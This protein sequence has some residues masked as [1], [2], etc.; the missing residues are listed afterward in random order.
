MN[1][2]VVSLHWQR[3]VKVP[4]EIQAIKNFMLKHEELPPEWKSSVSTTSQQSPS[5]TLSNKNLPYFTQALSKQ[6]F[7]WTLYKSTEWKKR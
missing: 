7:A 5:K 2:I 6:E 1:K 3:E 4:R